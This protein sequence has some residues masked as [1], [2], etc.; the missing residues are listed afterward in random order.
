MVA[1]EPATTH[2]ASLGFSGAAL[3]PTGSPNRPY[4][5]ADAPGGD[6]APKFSPAAAAAG[7]DVQLPLEYRGFYASY[8]PRAHRVPQ[9]VQSSAP[10]VQYRPRHRSSAGL[11]PMPRR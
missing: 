1:Y 11:P 3:A 4:T 9:P 2:S 7:V 8:A 5:N 10:R 6:A